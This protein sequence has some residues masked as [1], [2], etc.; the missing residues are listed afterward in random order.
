MPDAHIL[1]LEELAAELSAVRRQRPAVRVVHCHGVFD[2]QHIG[3]VRYL[4]A[5]RRLGG[6]DAVLVVT[7]T[8][9]H[10]VNKGPDRPAFS[11]AYRA[12][13][14]AALSCVDYVAINTA[15]TAVP[16]F[17]LLRP[18]V[19]AKGSEYRDESGDAT[20]A[21]TAEREAVEA[22]GGRLS[23]T[24]EVVFS[25]SELLNRH[26]RPPDPERVAYLAAYRAEF[27]VLAHR[28]AVAVAAGTIPVAVA[29]DP[30]LQE[31]RD[32]AVH[33]S[34]L[35]E[36]VGVVWPRLAAGACW[37]SADDG[38]ERFRS[39]DTKRAS[40]A[41]VISSKEAAAA[42]SDP[43]L[44]EHRPP[45]APPGVCDQAAGLVWRV[46]SAAGA[47]QPVAGLLSGLAGELC[48][49]HGAA[50]RRSRYLDRTA[51]VRHADTV[52]KL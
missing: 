48:G 51:L 19:Y 46:L 21:I 18:D 22:V 7:L 3:H 15:A 28:E 43:T 41:V 12:E 50:G 20:G 10:L 45:A 26:V 36:R 42:A 6:Q 38:R 34:G 23:F 40:G 44:A 5:A 11:A 25:S 27:G 1:L 52:L 35:V 29:G 9:D 17:E 14:L 47:A 8:P 16:L 39:W 24:D 4:Q 49:A 30:T 31:V 33:A 2:L 37:L 13:H 32:L